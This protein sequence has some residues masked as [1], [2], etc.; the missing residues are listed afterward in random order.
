MYKNSVDSKMIYLIL[1]TFTVILVLYKIFVI[2]IP[3]NFPPGPRLKIPIIETTL[4]EAYRLFIEQDEIEKHKE[5][6]R[7]YRNYLLIYLRN[8]YSF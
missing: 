7:R 6:S 8:T 3:S 1:I 2:R 4:E 5:Y